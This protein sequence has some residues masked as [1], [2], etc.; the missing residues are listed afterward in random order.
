MRPWKQAVARAF[1][2]AEGYDAAG[3][4][5]AMVARRLAQ[6]IA[7][8]PLP[9]SPRVLEIG[10][11]TAFLT[12]ALLDHVAPGVLIVSDLAPA[13]VKRARERLKDRPGSAFLVMDGERPCLSPGFDLICSSLAAQWFEDLE[14]TLGRLAGL[15]APG[16]FLAVTTLASDTFREWRDA[17]AAF[18]HHPA[19]PSYP[20][21]DALARL[22]F[23]GCTSHLSLEPV[24][25]RHADGRSFLHA[26]RSIGA[27]TPGSAGSLSPGALRAVIRRF[28]ESGS[29][30]TYEVAT[31]DIRRDRSR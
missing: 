21:A 18:G 5:Q 4:I 22:R 30:V 14:G 25:E 8:L 29:A 11:G 9:P 12:Q 24:V 31:L 1:D 7:S 10:C 26:L 15:L 3:V 13:M 6:R 23:E 16:G 2:G 17:H 28:E 20:T 27:G 19:T